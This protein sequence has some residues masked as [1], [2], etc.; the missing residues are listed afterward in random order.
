MRIVGRP[1]E[2]DDVPTELDAVVDRIVEEAPADRRSSAWLPP[3]PDR[4]V[5]DGES[6]RVV[7]G[8]LDQPERRR[9]PL[10]TWDPTDGHLVVLG[11]RRSGRTTALQNVVLALAG[12]HSAEAL[13]LHLLDAGRGLAV[14]AD[15]PHVSGVVPAD[16]RALL[17]RL[18]GRVDR[19]VLV[20]DGYDRLAT[21]DLDAVRLLEAIDGLARSGVVLIVASARP[22]RLPPSLLGDRALTIALR[23]DDA[24]DYGVLGLRPTA[25]PSTR[26]RGW[27]ADGDEVQLVAP[28]EPDV[29]TAVAKVAALA[30]VPRPGLGPVDLRPLPSEVRAIGALALRDRDLARIDLP[31]RPGVPLV[32]AGPPR[33]GRTHAF[34]HLL[35]QRADRPRS[36]VRPG[37]A[38]D[39]FLA[40]VAE[41][42]ADP[43][44]RTFAVDDAH[45]L[46][47]PDGRLRD[48]VARRHPDALV[49]LTV[50]TDTWRSSWLADLRPA[51]HGIALGADPL[52]DADLWTAPL[53]VLDLPV[54]P[55]RGVLLDAGTAEVVQVALDG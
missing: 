54:P 21:D 34:E 14:L 15:L 42:L 53:P 32:V 37:D 11:G 13:H 6:D 3:L 43:R 46:T 48:L 12:L 4:L 20:I 40:D 22:T 24:A 44:P 26:G 41:W 39:A 29:R 23:L 5:V 30:A 16:D 1:F 9:Q 7:L 51:G 25:R 33:S 38:P 36:V 35:R 2:H 8:R 19:G 50:R 28:P 17:R 55:G 49:L 47:D 45:L 31:V 52:H 10:L 18:V 27:T